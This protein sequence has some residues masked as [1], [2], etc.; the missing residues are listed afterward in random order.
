MEDRKGRV[1]VELKVVKLRGNSVALSG[2]PDFI[3]VYNSK[4]ASVEYADQILEAFANS[5]AV[6][7][8]PGNPRIKSLVHA[9]ALAEGGGVAMTPTML[10]AREVVGIR[11]VV[12]YEV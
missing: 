8:H 7:P 12:L 5:F 9:Q 2:D 10:L 3:G 6:K 1:T 11:A 4:D